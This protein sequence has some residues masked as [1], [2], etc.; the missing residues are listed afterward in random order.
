MNLM[1]YSV[2]RPGEVDSIPLRDGLQVGVVICILE[3][4]LNGVVIH[5]AYGKLGGDIREPHGFELKIGHGARRV[6]GE[7]LINPYAD[8]FSRIVGA[9]YEMLPQDL[10][11][12][13]VTH[14]DL[15][16]KS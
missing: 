2:S 3:A 10:L 13:G 8:L 7:R 1:A 14:K 15:Q 11:G 6:L 12:Q 16:Q 4:H 5:V 9:I